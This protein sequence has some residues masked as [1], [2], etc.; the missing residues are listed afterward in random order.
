M[1]PIRVSQALGELYEKI[2]DAAYECRRMTEMPE[3]STTELRGLKKVFR[4]LLRAQ[5]DL[6]MIPEDQE[7]RKAE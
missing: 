6:L 3:L 2:D 4:K 7:W 1:R 5:T